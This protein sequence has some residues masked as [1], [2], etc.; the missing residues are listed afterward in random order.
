MLQGGNAIRQRF[1]NFGNLAMSRLMRPVKLAYCCFLF[2][3]GTVGVNRTSAQ[4]SFGF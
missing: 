2:G 3:A 4:G 1:N